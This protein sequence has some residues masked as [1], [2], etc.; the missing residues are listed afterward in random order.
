ME[1]KK[2]KIDTITIKGSPKKV[3]QLLKEL[4]VRLRRD[5]LICVELEQKKREEV[6]YLAKIK[7]ESILQQKKQ[8][9]LFYK[10]KEE[11]APFWE[12]LKEDQIS[13]DFGKLSEESY[14]IILKEVREK[15]GG[16]EIKRNK[17]G[18]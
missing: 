6:K 2:N 7:E 1:Q 11:L 17:K 8:V 9:V 14:Q 5:K 13:I 3:K 12:Q 10:R 4:K 18:K 15:V 16:G